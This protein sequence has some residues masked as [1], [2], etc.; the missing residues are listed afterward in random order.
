MASTSDT[1]AAVEAGRKAATLAERFDVIDNTPE[2]SVASAAL[3]DSIPIC[4]RDN[5]AVEV[6]HDL[7][8]EMLGMAPGPRRR[9]S[10]PSFHELQSFIAYLNR[11]RHPLESVAFADLSSFS[12]EAIFDY[13][14]EGPE[15]DAA[16][17]MVHRASYVCPRSPEWLA[18]TE[19]EG[20]PQAQEAFADFIE[21]R[22]EDIASGDKKFPA[23]LDLLEMARNLMVRTQGQFQRTIDPTSG[24]GTL[25]N[26]TEHGAESTKIPR[27]FILGLRVFEGGALYQVEARLRFELREGR[28]MFTYSLHR[29]GEVERAAFSDVTRAVAGVVPVFAG[30]P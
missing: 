9:E 7:H 2:G 27:A 28:A 1:A 14:P 10:K 15:H 21:Q 19:R 13:H 6:A 24:T 16:R 18:W 20:K 12:V 30:K 25:I 22:L 17:W 8:E 29:R 23:A 26:K 3:W 11:H 4:L 5:G